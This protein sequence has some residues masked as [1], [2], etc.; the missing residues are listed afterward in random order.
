MNAVKEEYNRDTDNSDDSD[1]SIF[2]IEELST[3]KGKGKPLLVNLE[4]TDATN[5]YKT[6]LDCQLDTGATC[7]VISHKD[8]AIINQTGNPKVNTSKSKLRLFDGTI[9][10]PLGE[11]QLD[12]SKGRKQYSLK[13]QVVEGNARPLLSADVRTWDC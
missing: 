2:K 4:F 13:F 3:I 9:M 5:S 8:L 6:S 12:V 10:K 11:V 7:N 1:D